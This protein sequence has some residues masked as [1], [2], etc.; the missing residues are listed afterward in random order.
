MTRD[1]SQPLTQPAGA[2]G[3]PLGAAHPGHL[4]RSRGLQLRISERRLL[5]RLGDTGATVASV[6]LALW[7]WAREAGTPFTQDFFQPRAFWL[8][9]L[10]ALWLVLAVANN[11]Y[12]LR[13][14]ARLRSSL[15]HLLAITLQLLILYLGAYF[16][17]PRTLLPRDFFLFFAGASLVLTGFWRSCR[18]FLIGWTD[19]RRRTL[20]IGAGRP[21]ELITHA[22]KEEAH[23]DY[24]VVGWVTSDHDTSPPPSGRGAQSGDPGGSG[25][26]H[27]AR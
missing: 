5:M 21:A 7:L 6:L 24:E 18:L 9:V 13:V 26:D 20:I 10:P 4:G 19:F 2:E 12:D 11:Y 25:R 1:V 27:R 23:G 3:A 17:A 15:T 8:V 16:L 14:A 22:I